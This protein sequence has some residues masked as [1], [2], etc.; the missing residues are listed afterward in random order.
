MT[1]LGKTIL[2]DRSFTTDTHPFPQ[3]IVSNSG[4]VEKVIFKSLYTERG[5]CLSLDREQNFR[6]VPV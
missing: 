2:G 1:R 5:I 3:D 4:P 6:P